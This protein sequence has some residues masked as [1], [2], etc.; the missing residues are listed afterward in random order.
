MEMKV[1]DE[2]LLDTTTRNA[3]ES[4][5]LRKNYNFHKSESD[6]VNWMLN[7]LQRGTFVQPHRHL[8]PER[9]EMVVVLRGRVASFVF[10]EAGNVTQKAVI[11][12]QA[13]TYG[14]HIPAGEWHGLLVLQDGGL[15]GEAGAFRSVD[16]RECG[17]VVAFSGRCRGGYPVSRKVGSGAGI[18]VGIFDSPAAWLFCGENRKFSERLYHGTVGRRAGRIVG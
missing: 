16:A 12:P 8:A 14:F 7:G 9:D 13:G 11:D 1:I 6:P 10:D 4:P 3:E 17:S 2:T 18:K 15:R 5:R